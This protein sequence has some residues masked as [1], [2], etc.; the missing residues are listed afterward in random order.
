VA[1]GMISMSATGKFSKTTTLLNKLKQNHI[2]NILSRYGP[3]GVAALAAA[4]PVESGETA[5]SWYYR[6]G[7]NNGWYYLEFHNKHVVDG[8]PI[9]I[10][11][12]Y[13]HGTRTGGYVIGRDYINPA[14]KPLFEQI[15][16][17]VLKEVSSV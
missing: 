1:R 16:S 6:V 4:T 15:K 8:V 11:I 14:I 12:Q 17:D 10:L 2:T 5:N 3:Q 13:G 7:Q 9:A